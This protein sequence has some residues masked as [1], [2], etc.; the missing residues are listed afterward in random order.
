MKTKFTKVVSFFMSAIM[1]VSALSLSGFSTNAETS[2]S[3][4]QT[5]LQNDDMFDSMMLDE[6]NESIQ[7]NVDDV[8]QDYV[9][10]DFYHDFSNKS[11]AVKYCAKNDCTLFVGFYN[12]EGTELISSATSELKADNNGYAEL[13]INESLPE[14]YLIKAFLIGKEL[15]NPMSKPYIYNQCTS[16]M[17]EILKT[18]I[19]DFTDEERVISFGSTNNNFFVLQDDVT[20]IIPTETTDIYKGKDENDNYIFE[21][22][23][24]TAELKEG[25]KVFVNSATDMASFIV[26][27][28][29][30]DGNNVIVTHGE[31]KLNDFIKFM[32]YDSKDYEGEKNTS[33]QKDEIK[34]APYPRQLSQQTESDDPYALQ[35]PTI[36]SE[37]DVSFEDD[38][39]MTIPLSSGTFFDNKTGG[40]FS[41]ELQLNGHIKVYYDCRFGEKDF[42]SINFNIINTLKVTIGSS[43]DLLTLPDGPTNRFAIVPWLL[44]FRPMLVVTAQGE[45][46]ITYEWE[47]SVNGDTNSGIVPHITTPELKN[48]DGKVTLEITIDLSV[49]L[50]IGVLTICKIVPRGGVRV[51]LDAGSSDNPY[52]RHDCKNCC[53]IDIQFFVGI[54]IA[55]CA[56]FIGIEEFG[57]ERS[58][59]Y[60]IVASPPIVFHIN[61]NEKAKGPCKNKSH[62]IRLNVYEE[63]KHYGDYIEKGEP[64]DGAKLYYKTENGGTCTLK[65]DFDEPVVTD[66]KGN[67]EVWVKDVLLCDKTFVIVAE[68]EDGKNGQVNVGRLF[69]PT[70]EDINSFDII[71]DNNAEGG[72]PVSEGINCGL[73]KDDPK[74]RTVYNIDKRVGESFDTATKTLIKRVEPVDIVD[75][76]ETIELPSWA[77][78]EIT[79]TATGE[80]NP[81]SDVKQITITVY[82]PTD[83][84]ICNMD[85]LGNCHVSGEGK[86]Y[87]SCLEAKL[88]EKGEVFNSIIF[89]TTI[90]FSNSWFDELPVKKVTISD[91]TGFE[92]RLPSFSGNSYLTEINI[93]FC[94]K[95]IPGGMCNNCTNLKKVSLYD[96]VES[97]GDSAFSNTSIEEF[98]CPSTLKSIGNSSFYNCSKLSYVSFNDGLESIGYTA[99]QSTS[100][101]DIKFPSTLKSIGDGSFFNCANL[102]SVE[103]NEGLKEIPKEAFFNSFLN[104][105]K[106][107]D[108][109]EKIG[110]QAFYHS[111][112]K[113]LIL[114]EGLKTI[115]YQAFGANDI[116]VLDLPAS[117]EIINQEAFGNCSC[118]ETVIIN[119]NIKE[120]ECSIFGK[121]GERHIVNAIIKDGVTELPCTIFWNCES[122]SAVRLPEGLKKIGEQA[123][124]GCSSLEGI[125]LPDSITEIGPRAFEA[126]KSLAYVNI[127]KSLTEIEDEAFSN[128]GIKSLTIPSNITKINKNAFSDNNLWSLN[129]SES[130]TY[131]GEMAFWGNNLKTLNIPEGVTYI[132]D[133]AFENTIL[134]KI[135][136]PKSVTYLGASAFEGFMKSN[137]L[138]QDIYILNP[139]CEF[140]VK[141]WNVASNHSDSDYAGIDNNTIIYGY[142]G[143][144]AEK[145]VTDIKN[146]SIE[147]EYKNKISFKIIDSDPLTT[148]TTTNVTTTVT[149]KTTT[150]VTTN[151]SPDKECVMVAV[152]DSINENVSADDVLNSDKL[153]FFDQSTAD[154]NGVVSFAYVPN[155]DEIWSFMFISEVV[156]NVIQRTIGA[157]DDMKT[158]LETTVSGDAN[159]DGEVDM[160][161]AVLIMQALANPNKY[162]LDGTAPVHLT[163][164]NL[165]YSDVEGEGNGLTANDALQIQKYLLGQ[166]TSLSN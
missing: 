114:N 48:I 28:I 10:Y 56:E 37:K 107:P 159:G 122:L 89:D 117:L 126:C 164:N 87:G 72:V 74:Y 75:V 96:S 158:I 2:E 130:V 110:N 157:I 101:R 142:E 7:N 43:F 78:Y 112:I 88:I 20:E 49:E 41:T 59:D 42:L 129:I 95:K 116:Y 11:V 33:G 84:I 5:E 85:S 55:F 146:G 102:N 39:S 106:I 160:S 152:N 99:F 143:S 45:G 65:D 70:L 58:F 128:A 47:V 98:E 118:L 133:R 92:S 166:I 108:S 46:T 93:L 73:D 138:T 79:N 30:T 12:D 57:F 35:F 137:N 9:I 141:F 81:P 71:L 32:K 86:I 121:K 69:N 109:V 80:K 16:K 17:Q 76:Y 66:S 31:A 153:R 135:Y 4:E 53:E 156:D 145:Y 6:F 131:I 29:E 34:R 19:S 68:S 155:N 148:V 127:P 139:E 163:L 111:Q 24:K 62:M 40:S 36:K 13:V 1:T 50:D 38:I 140:N 100:I 123:F 77:L 105:V 3:T 21:N 94:N 63:G 14:H 151:M 120:T 44:Y 132:G 134:T 23:V 25:D 161:D 27:S 154:E 113:N 22:A 104:E 61:E 51:V 103:L 147:D 150:V 136:V 82:K 97:I 60:D 165:K 125:Y 52:V 15:L 144:T 124:S 83:D 91:L 67:A 8:S 162:G 149:T 54:R 115:G 119:G 64:S 26:E 18:T 90:D